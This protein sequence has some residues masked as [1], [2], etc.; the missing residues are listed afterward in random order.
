MNEAVTRAD[1]H[2]GILRALIDRDSTHLNTKRLAQFIVDNYNMNDEIC[3]LSSLMYI[4]QQIFE[5]DLATMIKMVQVVVT[6]LEKE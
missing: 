4:C 6:N 5:E 2:I 1:L 3:M